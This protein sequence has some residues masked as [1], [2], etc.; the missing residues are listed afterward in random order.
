MVVRK[1]DKAGTLEKQKTAT[2]IRPAAPQYK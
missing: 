2:K 1:T